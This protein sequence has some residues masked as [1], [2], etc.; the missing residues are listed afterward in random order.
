MLILLST[1]PYVMYLYRV[2]PF[3]SLEQNWFEAVNEAGICLDVSIIMLLCN[4]VYTSEQ[5]GYI[6]WA[7]IFAIS[8]VLACNAYRLTKKIL[9]SHLYGN[10]VTVR[11]HYRNWRYSTGK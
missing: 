10:F 8:L 1:Y 6:G 2:K 7:L 9:T 5:R 4:S 11:K 3:F